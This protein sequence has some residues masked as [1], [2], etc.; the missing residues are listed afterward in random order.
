MIKE[1]FLHYIWKLKKIDFSNLK[2]SDGEDVTI[3]DFGKY[4][5]DSGPDF[6]NA[7]VKIDDTIWREI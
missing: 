6:F 3:L 5:T 7:K 2:T 4:N 1:D